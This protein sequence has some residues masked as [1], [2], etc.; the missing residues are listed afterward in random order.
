MQ[1]DVLEAQL[2]ELKANKMA[3]PQDLL[4]MFE[5]FS[6]WSIGQMV[7]DQAYVLSARTQ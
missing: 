6:E 1:Y 4:S 5:D 3:S 2:A 7:N